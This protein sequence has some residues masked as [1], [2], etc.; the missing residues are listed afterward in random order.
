[1]VYWIVLVIVVFVVTYYHLGICYFYVITY[2]YSMLDILLDQNLYVSQGLFTVVS[3]MS[4]AAKVTPQFLG[5]LCLVK[6]MSGIDQQVIHYVHPLAVTIIVGI[7]C[8]LARMSCR[9]S[10]FISRVIIRVI[11]FLL[12]LTHTSVATTSLLLLR[13]LTFQNVNKVYTYLSPDIEYFHG[14]HLPYT[15][16]A[17]LCTLVIVI[18]LPLLLLLEPF[19]NGK[20]DFTR[21]KPLL[22]QFQG[23]YKDKY[24]PFASYYIICRLLIISITIINSSNNNATQILLH[25]TTILVAL[26]HIT[27]KPYE[28]KL[29]NILDGVVLTAMI[30]VSFT[31]FIDSLGTGVQTSVIIFLVVVPLVAFVAMELVLYKEDIKK[32]LTHFKPKPATTDCNDNNVPPMNDIGL[33]IDDNM[34][35]NATIVDIRRRDSNDAIEIHNTMIHY[36]EPIMEIMNDED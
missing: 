20:V 26:I 10:A 23:C 27:I 31:F 2:Y 13:S 30:F 34:R 33:V 1:M 18:G 3:I 5:Q 22:D 8:L 35:K 21:I 17:I 12:L 29:L 9:F 32:I 25:I 36:R 7:I 14:R 4:S 24:R 19:L 6:N 15:I 16:I 11:C 28:S